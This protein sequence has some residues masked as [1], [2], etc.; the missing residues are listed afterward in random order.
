MLITKINTMGQIV[1]PAKIRKHM[2]INP[3]TNLLIEE[4]GDTIIIKTMNVDYFNELAGVLRTKGKLSK[5]LIEDRIA[6][7]EKW[8]RKRYS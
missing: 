4:R 1:I 3:G 6:E 7:K 8:V 2:N 5:S